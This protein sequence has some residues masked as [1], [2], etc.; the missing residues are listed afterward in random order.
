[1]PI[2]SVT[3]DLRSIKT[4]K[5]LNIAMYTLLKN[6][7]FRKMTVRDICEAALISRATFYAHFSDKYD[8]LKVWLTQ[9]I[10]QNIS[11]DDTFEKLEKEINELV[12]NNETII[13]NL[14]YGADDETLGILFDFILFF[15]S[16]KSGEENSEKANAKF[17]VLSNFYAGG[18]IYYTLWHVKNK[19]P[20]HTT[21]MNKYLY[22][23]IGKF[24]E[25][26]SKSVREANL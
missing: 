17:V 7:G 9:L 8:F 6:N 23:L 14:V 18:M 10:P 20:A 22:D 2:N 13:K 1:M 11:K 19:F 25:W 26:Q 16:F 3:G 12:H 21:P 15:S 24:C 5:A 4:A